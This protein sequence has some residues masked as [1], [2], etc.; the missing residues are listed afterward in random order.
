MLQTEG[1]WIYMVLFKRW[2]FSL[3]R[4][5]VRQKVL[6]LERNINRFLWKVMLLTGLD[7]RD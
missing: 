6:R 4:H 2:I 5:D 1:A 7:N 3:L